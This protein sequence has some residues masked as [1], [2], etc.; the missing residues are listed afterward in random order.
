MTRSAKRSSA[1]RWLAGI[2]VLTMLAGAGTFQ[3]AAVGATEPATAVLD[4]NLYAVNALSNPLPTATPPPANPGAG[5]TPP[6]ASI[7]LAMVQGAV[8]D[9]VNTI[10]GRFKAYLRHLPDA[11]R[12]ASKSAAAVTAAH[13]VLVG[14]DAGIVPGLPQVVQDNLDIL[15][16]TSLAAIPNGPAKTA[17]IQIGAAVAARM[18]AKRADDGRYV[19]FSFVVGSDPGEWRPTPTGFVND[20]FAWV[21]NVKPFT[22]RNTHQFRT[23]GPDELDSD[24]YTKEY[25]EVK[26]MGSLTGSGRDATQTATAN[27][28]TAN[29]LVML[30]RMLRDVAGAEGLSITRAARLFVMSSMSGADALINCWD[31]KDH[32]SFWRPIT[33][34]RGAATDGNDDTEAQADWTP[35]IATPPYP[36]HPSGYNCFSAATLHAAK[37]FFHTNHMSFVLTTPAGATWSYDRFTAVLTDTIDARVWLGIH[38]R[39]PDVQGARLGKN[40]ARWVDHHFFGVRHH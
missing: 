13:D 14:L 17:G 6:V 32:Y 26:L 20:P 12:W 4:W 28:F 23:K 10:G 29:P 31:D 25:N 11:P 22:L 34:I 36:D 2:G 9:A 21:A 3:V 27:F 5:Q 8:F 16:D 15:R 24:R 7:H 33:A 35:L 40:V 18:L 19:A 38:F 30:N 39:N 1:R 37:R